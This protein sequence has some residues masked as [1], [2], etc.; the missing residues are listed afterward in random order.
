MSVFGDRGLPVFQAGHCDWQRPHSVHVEKS[1]RPFHEK[2]AMVATP[3]GCVSGSAVSKSAGSPS[4]S[5]GLA[6]PSETAPSAL[7]L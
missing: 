5:I 6:A 2:S 3:N 1:S 7:R 4:M